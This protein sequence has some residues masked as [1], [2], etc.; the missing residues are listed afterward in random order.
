MRRVCTGLIGVTAMLAVTVSLAAAEIVVY[1]NGGLSF[2]HGDDWVLSIGVANHGSWLW[3]RG[4][5]GQATVQT[6]SVTTRF[7]VDLA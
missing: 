7:A 2:S 3:Q 5:T 6:Q 1:G 4:G